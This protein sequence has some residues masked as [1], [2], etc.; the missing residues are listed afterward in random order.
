MYVSSFFFNQPYLNNNRSVE[1]SFFEANFF[2]KIQICSNGNPMELDTL[3]GSIKWPGGD[4]YSFNAQKIRLPD[5][6][7]SL[8]LKP[9][10]YNQAGY[11]G[12]FLDR[13]TRLL[14]FIQV[15]IQTEHSFKWEHFNTTIRDLDKYLGGDFLKKFEIYFIVPQDKISAFSIP[16][17]GHSGDCKGGVNNA[18]R[19]A[20]INGG[21]RE[22]TCK[23]WRK[24]A[25]IPW[26]KKA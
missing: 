8:W 11:D 17:D 5:T 6:P 2:S 9:V 23:D 25:G 26:G 14:R 20:A 3:D 7:S 22:C 19:S 4:L 13:D 21:Q 1:G 10:K 24:V 15:T 12:L 18:T 16:K